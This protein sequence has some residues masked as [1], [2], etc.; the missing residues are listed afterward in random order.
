MQQTPWIGRRIDLW[1]IIVHT[2]VR[3][4]TLLR[5]GERGIRKRK[6]VRMWTQR[7]PEKQRESVLV[8]YF[9]LWR[10][11]RTINQ[12]FCWSFAMWINFTFIETS[13]RNNLPGEK[14]LHFT[15][16]LCIWHFLSLFTLTVVLWWL[17]RY[18]WRQLMART[19]HRASGGEEDEEEEATWVIAVYTMN[20]M[21]KWK[22]KMIYTWETICYTS[23][24]ES[25]RVVTFAIT[26]VRRTESTQWARPQRTEK[27]R[28]REN[29]LQPLCVRVCDWCAH[30]LQYMHSST[31]FLCTFRSWRTPFLLS[32]SL[33]SPSLCL[34]H[35]LTFPSAK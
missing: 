18:K 14:N 32:L 29:L 3:V 13:W 7:G 16:Q 21:N 31:N 20:K 28:E 9:V 34:L 23:I 17:L 1:I 27:E 4:Y 15:Q 24:Y 22:V 11:R 6:V 10:V 25:R 8:I 33:L 35:C 2:D 26:S 19:I 12:M 30:F 5:R